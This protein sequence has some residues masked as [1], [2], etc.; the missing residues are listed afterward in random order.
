MQER[1]VVLCDDEKEI[2]RYLKKILLAHG[3]AVDTYA[4]GQTLLDRLEADSAYVPALLVQDICMPG[5]DGIDILKQVRKLRP[6]MPVVIM[7]AFGSIDSAVEAIKLGAYDY[8]TKPFPN[9][10]LIDALAKALERE[11]LLKENRRLK[12]ELIRNTA[13]GEIVFASSKFRAVYDMTLQVAQSEANILIQGES[14]TGKELIARAIHF[15][16]ARR[17]GSYLTINCAALTDTLLE[18]QLF[19]HMR[20]AFTGATSTQKGLLEAAD[21]GTLFLDEIGDMTLALQAKLLRVIQEREFTPVGSTVS[22]NTDIRIVAA[23]N[24][25]LEREVREGRFR[26][27]LYYR[28]NVI[29]L[30]PPPLRERKE[31]LEPLARHFLVKF[32][33]KMKKQVDGITGDAM[34]L[35]SD[36]H[37]PGNI[38]ELENIIERA[39]ILARGSKV[40]ADLLP[41]RPSAGAPPAIVGDE[42]DSLESVER[43]HI[44]WIL[45]KN[46][47]R[48]RRSAEILGITRKTLDRKIAEYAIAIPRGS[49]EGG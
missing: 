4:E 13:P 33:R 21:G 30:N 45:K 14:G 49:T 26:E 12:E 48:K 42:K 7:T 43:N 37:W 3:Y 25:D 38:R 11:S 6:E 17:E 18:S 29:T 41:I 19:G 28:L 5:V 27:D 1:K 20:G 23:T 47:Y 16:S 8:I 40:T 39:V 34:R 9:E 44:I 15:N 32:S 24:K 2:L 31:D 22:R 46:A 35:L 36:Y 10:K